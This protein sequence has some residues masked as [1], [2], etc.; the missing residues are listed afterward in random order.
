MESVKRWASMAVCSSPTATQPARQ[1]PRGCCP[2]RPRSLSVRGRTGQR[3]HP[4]ESAPHGRWAAPR[5]GRPVRA[6][7]PLRRSAHRP[8]T[9]GRSIPGGRL[10]GPGGGRRQR[11]RGPGRSH[12]GRHRVV[13]QEQQRPVAR[14]RLLVRPR[15]GRDRRPAAADLARGR[16]LWALPAVPSFLP[17]RCPGGSG[18][19][20]RPCCLAWFLQ[21]PGVFPFEYRAALGD[22]IYGCDDCQDVC[23]PNRACCGRLPGAPRGPVTRPASTSGHARRHRPSLMAHYGRWYIPRRDPRYLQRNALIVLANG[24]RAAPGRRSHAEALPVRPGR[25]LA[26][27]RR[28]GGAE[29]WPRG[30]CGRHVDRVPWPTTLRRWSRRNCAGRSKLWRGQMPR[31]VWAPPRH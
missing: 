13:R 17:Y 4:A 21:A 29:P 8:R 25:P 18:C 26:G 2:G 12:P 19:L 15:C 11:F 28:L 22:R 20:R 16:R 9:A 31:L 10:G 3:C 30:P 24:R 5:P 23:P 1:T 27:P 14:R 6:A 7:G